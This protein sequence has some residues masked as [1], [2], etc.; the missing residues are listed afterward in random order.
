MDTSDDNIILSVQARGWRHG[1]CGMSG[2]V[3]PNFVSGSNSPPKKPWAGTMAYQAI[4]GIMQLNSE[5]LAFV[6]LRF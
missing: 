1:T 3:F 5:S 4:K 6:L 2:V